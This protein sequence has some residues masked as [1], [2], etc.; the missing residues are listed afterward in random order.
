MTGKQFTDCVEKVSFSICDIFK[1]YNVTDKFKVAEFF[2]DSWWGIAKSVQMFRGAMANNVLFSPHI[3]LNESL[4]YLIMITDPKL[5]LFA[6]SPDV[7]SRSLFK[8]NEKAGV[9]SFYL[10]ATKYVKLNQPHNPCEPSSD[11]N[12]AQCVEKKIM[13]RAGCQPHWRRFPTQDLPECDN[14]SMLTQYG[15]EYWKLGNL[16]RE[17]LI[18]V[19]GCHLP[20][21]FMKY[22]VSR[23]IT[24]NNSVRKYTSKI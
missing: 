17:D 22:T 8:R 9:Y 7:I 15:E 4:K 1:S 6:A 12:F 3:A 23:K 10:K 5:Q 20:C 16:Y 13:V 18:D 21:T 2:I 24:K 11:Y 14:T 19:T